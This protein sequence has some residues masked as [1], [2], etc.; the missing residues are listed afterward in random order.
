VSAEE[1]P[2]EDDEAFDARHLVLGD[3][4]NRVL[5]KG[6]VISGQVMISVA[7]IDLLMVDLRLLLT[8]VQTALERTTSAPPARER[9]HGDST[10]LPSDS[11]R[12]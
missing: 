9:E 4:I 7:D 5:D 11:G 6:V 8:S 10:V 3:L 2:P 12:A 1:L